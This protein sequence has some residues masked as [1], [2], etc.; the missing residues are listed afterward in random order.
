MTTNRADINELLLFSPSGSE[1]LSDSEAPASDSEAP[2]SDSA[3]EAPDSAFAS[4][5]DAA[6]VSLSGSDPGSELDSLSGS[7]APE[8]SAWTRARVRPRMSNKYSFMVEIRN[9]NLVEK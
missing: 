8:S 7:D 3:S 4:L 1:E 2:D 6:L 9:I 5:S